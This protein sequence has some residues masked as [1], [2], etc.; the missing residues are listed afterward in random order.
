MVRVSDLYRKIE[1]THHAEL[2]RVYPVISGPEFW[3]DLR[4]ARD[5]NHASRFPLL[6]EPLIEAIPQYADGVK[7][8][9]LELKDEPGLDEIDK[10][11]LE[12]LGH[13][14]NAAGV[15]YDLYPHQK[16][17]VLSH[18]S[19][20]D[21]VIATGTGSGKLRIHVPTHDSPQR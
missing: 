20:D 18:V 15:N 21:V 9:P 11:R 7:S 16:A 3:G 12:K 6:N 4:S 5:E 13:L 19:G 17:S 14:L 2:R 1:F 10:S 8:K